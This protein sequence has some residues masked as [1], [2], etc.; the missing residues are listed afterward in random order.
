[1]VFHDYVGIR[2]APR[3]VSRSHRRSSQRSPSLPLAGSA[4]VVGGIGYPTCQWGVGFF[5]FWTTFG[6]SFHKYKRFVLWDISTVYLIRKKPEKISLQGIEDE[7][8]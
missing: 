6:E 3:A 8:V 7:H 1:M 5:V 4:G 2:R